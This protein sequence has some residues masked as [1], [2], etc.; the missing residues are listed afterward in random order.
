MLLITLYS[1]IVLLNPSRTLVEIL[2]D[3]FGNAIGSVV[4]VFYIWYFIHLASLVFRDFGSFLVTTT[5]PRT[6]MEVIIALF[7]LSIIYAANSGIEVMGRISETLYHYLFINYYW[8]QY[9]NTHDYRLS[10][11]IGNGIKPVIKESFNLLTFPL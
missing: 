5:Y 10:S 2:R 9:R 11:C 3:R 1:L 7:A 4:A 6:P 8:R